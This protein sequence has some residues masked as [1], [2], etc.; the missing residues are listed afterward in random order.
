MKLTN[1]DDV[2]HFEAGERRSIEDMSEEEA[3]AIFG[4]P[5]YEAWLRAKLDPPM[6]GTC[7][8]TS[9]DGSGPTLTIDTGPGWPQSRGTPSVDLKADPENYATITIRK[10]TRA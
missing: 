4:R 5:V 3:V 6:R 7:V 2:R 9:I 8:V 10:R 1:P